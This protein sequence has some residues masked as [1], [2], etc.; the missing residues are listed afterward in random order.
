MSLGHPGS[1]PLTNLAAERNT[2]R[3]TAF[4]K[5]IK[6]TLL[7]P[8]TLWSR[9]SFILARNSTSGIADEFWNDDPYYGELIGTHVLGQ[10]NGVDL[11]ELEM[12]VQEL[13]ETDQ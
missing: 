13:D 11:G 10:L 4:A 2:G 9:W 12:F 8:L 1:C 3:I 6:E 7:I 5:V